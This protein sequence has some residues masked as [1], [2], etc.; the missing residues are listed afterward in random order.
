MGCSSF[1]TAPDR[2]HAI[3]VLATYLGGACVYRREDVRF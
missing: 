2:L 1:E 3:D